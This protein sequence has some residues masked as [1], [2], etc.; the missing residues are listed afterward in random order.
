M[1]RLTPGETWALLATL[2]ALVA[3]NAP[4]LGSMPWNFRPGSV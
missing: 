2:G 1:R 4:I 3:V